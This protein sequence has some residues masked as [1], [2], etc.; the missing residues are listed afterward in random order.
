[1][2]NRDPRHV[3]YHRL[4][5]EG[6]VVAEIAQRFNV[7]PRRVRTQIRKIDPRAF[8]ETPTVSAMVLMRSPIVRAGLERRERWKKIAAEVSAVEGREV[9]EKT[10]VMWAHRHGIWKRGK[11]LN[12]ILKDTEARV[13]GNG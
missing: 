2:K 3:T 11:N 7:T 8:H 12:F 10:L 13:N 9:R 1:M 4:M 5:T 6:V